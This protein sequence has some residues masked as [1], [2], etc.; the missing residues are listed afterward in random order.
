ML[1]AA[2]MAG[3]PLPHDPED[4][5]APARGLGLDGLLALLERLD[6]AQEAEVVRSALAAGVPHDR[7]LDELQHEVE[8]R[9]ARVRDPAEDHW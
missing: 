6:G 3:S 9:L 7:V 5:L 1:R 4:P 2:Y 8:R